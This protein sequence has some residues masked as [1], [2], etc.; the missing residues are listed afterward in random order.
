MYVKGLLMKLLAPCLAHSEYSLSIIGGI[1]I[2]MTVVPSFVKQRYWHLLEK[3]A[4]RLWK[5]L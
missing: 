4:L 2:L 3:A 5:G 1:I